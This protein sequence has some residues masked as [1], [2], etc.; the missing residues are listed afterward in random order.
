MLVWPG[1]IP[2]ETDLLN[3]QRNTL[4]ALGFLI[5][6]LLGA[7][8]V[9]GGFGC[10]PGTGLTVSIAPGRIYS[11]QNLDGTAYSS[12]PAD[13]THQVMK[14]GILLDAATLDVPAPTTSGDSINYLIEAAYE[15]SDTGN[16]ILDYY[17]ASNSTQPYAGPNNTGQAQPT[18]R[19]GLV[20]LVAKP[21]AAAATGSQTAPAADAGYVGLYV[22][23]VANGASGVTSGD[24]TAA[25]GA[26]FIASPFGAQ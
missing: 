8:T 1:A 2:L 22:V 15:D 13:L 12:L 10:T 26:P 11:L 25:S 4:I 24:I 21:G 18:M 3:A 20:A 9:V 23:T 6:D 19:Q 14:Q 17:D 7:N 5:K 16:T